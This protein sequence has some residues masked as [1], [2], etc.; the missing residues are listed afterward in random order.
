MSSL[1]TRV[2]IPMDLNAPLEPSDPRSSTI[3]TT[4]T[5]GTDSVEEIRFRFESQTNSFQ[6]NPPNRSSLLHLTIFSPAFLSSSNVVVLRFEKEGTNDCMVE[7]STSV[8]VLAAA[9]AAA[10]AAG[11]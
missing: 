9:L 3:P 2:T 10:A 4:L 8:A 11:R 6:S 5:G 1:M 7:L